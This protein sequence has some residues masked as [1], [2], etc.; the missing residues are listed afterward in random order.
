MNKTIVGNIHNQIY[1]RKGTVY[2]G[3]SSHTK[4][5]FGNPFTHLPY[6]LGLVKVS[7]RDEAVDNFESWLDGSDWT[8][9]EPER[10]Q[11]ILDHIP[12][13]KGK[14]L[15]YYC[16]PYKC[17]GDSLARRADES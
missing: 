9:L 10:R 15:I 1:R 6:G 2:I 14:V 17:H 16:K 13:L 4:F 3:G 7:T 5:H 12:E 11:W 8:D